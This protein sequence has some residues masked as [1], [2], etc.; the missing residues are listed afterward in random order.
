M[1]YDSFSFRDLLLPH[2]LKKNVVRL[3]AA[4]VSTSDPSPT[5]LY[6]V[7]LSLIF[8]KGIIV[9]FLSTNRAGVFGTEV[10]N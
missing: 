6:F 3:D 8:N 9:C 10:V 5:Y 7:F 4:L 2:F 1:P